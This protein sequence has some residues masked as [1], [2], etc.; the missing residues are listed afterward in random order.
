MG[1]IAILIVAVGIRRG[2]RPAFVTGAGTATA[3]LLYASLAVIGGAALAGTLKTIDTPMR[4]VSGL[5]LILVAIVGLRRVGQA[6]DEPDQVTDLRG[7]GL[8][9][10]YARFL[11]LTIINPTTI[12]DFAAVIIG[13]G[14]SDGLTAPEGALFVVGAFLASLSW[15]TVVAA[16]GSLARR[17]LSSCARTVAIVIGN[18]LILV[19]GILIVI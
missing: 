4:I 12:V 15:Q 7:N 16:I 2:F 6:T 10:I 1:A 19:F 18:L 5:V 3:D 17:R 14:V 13:L 9:R 8:A 11:G